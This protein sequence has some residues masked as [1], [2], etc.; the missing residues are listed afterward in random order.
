MWAC[1]VPGERIVLRWPPT[2]LIVV[3]HVVLVF[4]SA[5]ALHRQVAVLWVLH[6]LLDA[7]DGVDAQDG[8]LLVAEAAIPAWRVEVVLLPGVVPLVGGLALVV[9]VH[10]KVK[11]PGLEGCT[12]LN[13]WVAFLQ[14]PE[15]PHPGGFVLIKRLVGRLGRHALHLRVIAH[16]GHARA[17]AQVASALHKHEVVVVVVGSTLRPTIVA[18]HQRI[19]H[20]LAQE[21]SCWALLVWPPL[22]LLQE[23]HPAR[24]LN[25]LLHPVGGQRVAWRLKVAG[26]VFLAL[27][28]GR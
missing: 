12:F 26:W 4:A 10:V 9:I 22:V 6:R 7:L 25:A 5:A 2:V 8:G 21:P 11:V 28:K 23:P 14:E 20:P 18:L 16:E 19:A 1:L 17:A 15:P 24:I 3:P 27:V 13:Q